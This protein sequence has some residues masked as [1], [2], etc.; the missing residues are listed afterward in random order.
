V[1]NCLPGARQVGLYSTCAA[2][3]QMSTLTGV[4]GD[5]RSRAPRRGWPSGPTDRSAFSP[6]VIFTGGGLPSSK[7]SS[8]DGDGRRAC[9]MVGGG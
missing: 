3:D 2:C 5:A 4:E 9:D 6:G 7:K 1:G 8:L